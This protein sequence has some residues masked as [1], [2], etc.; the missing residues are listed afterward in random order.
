MKKYIQ[1]SIVS[2]FFL[3]LI[4]GGCRDKFSEQ[5]LALEPVYLSFADLRASVKIISQQ[6][7]V[8]PGKI[9]TFGNYIF[10]NEV[11]KGVHVY[12]NINPATP[13]YIGFINI[14]GNLD[15]AVRN[16]ILYADSYLDLVAIDV[17]DPSR[18][19]EV[20]RVKSTFSYSLPAKTRTDLRTGYVDWSRG[21][22]V[23]WEV[24]QVQKESYIEYNNADD[25]HSINSYLDAA[26]TSASVQG[27]GGSMARF[28]L[29]G[30]SLVTVDI[31]SYY[32]NFDLTDPSFPK[33]T[34]SNYLNGGGVET[35]FLT[36]KYMFLGT[37]NGMLIYDLSDPMKPLFL[38]SFWHA[39][40]CD[41]VVV[42][43]NRAYVTLRSGVTCANNRSTNE[44]SVLDITDVKAPVLLRSYG[45]DNPHGLGISDDILFVC[46]GNSGL[47]VYNAANPLLIAENLL[48]KFPGINSYDVIPLGK[49]LLMIGSDGFYQYDYSDLKNIKEISVIKVKK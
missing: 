13:Q 37:R 5:Y 1:N 20:G 48:A 43:N 11:M 15:L 41:P 44:L 38:S 23:D 35:M 29:I 30:N 17:T 25:F 21:I 39:T 36:G 7:L 4:L 16:N 14:P 18:A 40:G 32:C 46:D 19:K 47:K 24:K 45:M 2:I 28:G 12:N 3:G 27:V 31:N 22:V 9:Y 33:R 8:N 10:I 49:S 42:Q 26:A 34:Y 6:D